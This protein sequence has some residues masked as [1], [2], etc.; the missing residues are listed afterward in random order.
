MFGHDRGAAGHPDGA[1]V[2]VGN[3]LR[4]CRENAHRMEATR[5][6]CT[7]TTVRER[8]GLSHLFDSRGC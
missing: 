3:G 5:Q 8:L 7:G 4:I 1:Q 2:L 6:V